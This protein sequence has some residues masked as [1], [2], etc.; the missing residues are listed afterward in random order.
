METNRGREEWRDILKDWKRSDKRR[1]DFC[2]DRKLKVTAFDYWRRKLLSP[3]ESS[4][5]RL[6]RLEP[7]EIL[8]PAR[9]GIIQLKVGQRYTLEFQEDIGATHLLKVLKVLRDLV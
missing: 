8:R 1:I 5:S 7:A 4:D 6:V 3:V 9:S 2:R